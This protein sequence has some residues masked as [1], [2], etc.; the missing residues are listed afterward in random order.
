MKAY[1]I[2]GY[3]FKTNNRRNWRNNKIAIRRIIDILYAW[4]R[5]M[6]MTFWVTVKL[7][8]ELIQA[9]LVSYIYPV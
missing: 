6:K 2:F 1:K 4:D 8:V 3:Y 9:A 7:E 5:W